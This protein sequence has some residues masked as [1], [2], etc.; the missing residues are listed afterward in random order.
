MNQL[1]ALRYLAALARHRHFGRAAQACHITQP[2]LSNAIRA[3]EA[4]HG[5]ALVRRGRQY[6]GLTP[7]G[8]AVLAHGHRL[9]HE[10]EAL[11]QT[12]AALAGTPGGRLA[13]AAVPSALPV[14]A[15]FAAALQARHPGLEPELRSA[16]S[17]EIE[18]GLEALSL[19]L[20]LGYTGRAEVAQRRLDCCQ[21]YQEHYFLLECDGAA[22][23]LRFGAPLG[24][25]EAAGRRLVLLT[26]DMHHRHLVDGAF[27]QAGV[28]ARPALQTDSVLALQVAVQA[29]R[30][31]AGVLPGALVDGLRHQ[32]GLLAR[33]LGAPQ[34]VTP[35]GFLSAPGAPPTR[36]LQAAL[37]L[38]G[39]A[40]W[41]A[42]AR[43]HSGMLAPA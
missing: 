15:R 30:G 36:A 11:R 27:A 20:A 14:A 42:E 9:L 1:D 39:S 16:S 22:G 5:L 38:A 24:W 21:Q 4:H 43:A 29:G 17:P 18:A 7:E 35:I 23:P 25:A 10:A 34:L 2:A 31:L 32:P 6:L 33:P 8:E 26:P 12:V 13:L 28:A 37:D 19:D 3:L 40:D 41:L